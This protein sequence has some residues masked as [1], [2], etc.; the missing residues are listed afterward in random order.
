MIRILKKTIWKFPLPILGKTIVSIY[1]PFY[2][3]ARSKEN[4][5]RQS[6][7]NLNLLFIVKIRSTTE[8][9]TNKWLPNPSFRLR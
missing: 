8:L 2:S 7:I 3:C 6:C 4:I 5:L 9:Q 1:I